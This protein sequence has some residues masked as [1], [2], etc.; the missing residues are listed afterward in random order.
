MSFDLFIKI[1]KVTNLE[2]DIAED[3]YEEFKDDITKAQK[4]YYL[5]VENR[6]KKLLT[7]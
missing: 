1:L 7:I 3:V 6:Y 5:R 2:L 4:E